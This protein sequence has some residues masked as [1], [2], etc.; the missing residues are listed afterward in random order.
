MA[1]E[2]EAV[3]PTNQ[4]SSWTSFLKSIATFSGDLS[5][6]TAPSFILSPTSLCEFPSYW[7][8]PH[9]EFAA[10]STGKNPEERMILTLRWFISTLKGQFTRR[11]TQTGTEKKPLNPILG[12]L[13]LGSWNSGPS[14]DENSTGELR[15]WTEQVSHHPPVS[16]YCLI[17]AKAGVSYQ[18]HCG[19]KTS[20][21]GKSVIVKQVGHGLLRIKLPDNTI[22]SYLITLPKLRI[23]GLWMAS[24]YIELTENSHIQSSSGY[25]TV[26]EFKGKGYFSGKAHSFTAKIYSQPKITS[27]VSPVYEIEGQWHGFSKFVKQVPKWWQGSGEKFLDQTEEK[28]DEIT[29]QDISNQGPLESRRVWKDVADG[30]RSG[31]FEAASS[32]KSKL[33]NEQRAKRKEELANG[34]PWQ[35]SHFDRVD[36]DEEYAR[37]AEMC[38]HSPPTEEAYYFKFE[39]E[40][41]QETL[42]KQQQQE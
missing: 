24:P 36:S 18:G 29:V 41:I 33:E 12:E 19:Q 5:S 22:E 3:V 17:N 31:D 7:G 11:E 40:Y 6:L 1:T 25:H 15:L 42:S 8:E 39:N 20:F 4:R 35:M 23:E 13:F 32:A 2:E 37:L 34:T 27:G 16:A 30:I 14:T 9:R 38:G 10:I 21:S 28:L 26:L